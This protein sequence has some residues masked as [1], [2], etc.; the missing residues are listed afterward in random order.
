M[1]SFTQKQDK[2]HKSTLKT[3]PVFLQTPKLLFVLFFNPTQKRTAFFVKN[4]W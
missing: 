2:L 1:E 4:T 3:H